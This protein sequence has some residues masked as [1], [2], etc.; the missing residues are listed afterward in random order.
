MQL[1]RSSL[2]F[3]MAISFACLG[4]TV[5]GFFLLWVFVPQL[6]ALAVF[7]CAVFLGILGSIL[8]A[9]LVSKSVNRKQAAAD[10]AYRD[11][12]EAETQKG[13]DKMLRANSRIPKVS[14]EQ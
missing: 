1:T 4:S 2:L 10:R 3:P 6:S 7:V 13:I 8:A 9:S 14:K 11:M 5:V 12:R